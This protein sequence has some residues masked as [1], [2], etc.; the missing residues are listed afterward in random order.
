MRAEYHKLRIGSILIIAFVVLIAAGIFALNQNS[1]H[2]AMK[3]H[4]LEF[5]EIVFTKKVEDKL[6]FIFRK[7]DMLGELTFAKSSMGFRKTS[8]GLEPTDADISYFI[9][10]LDNK[11]ALLIGEVLDEETKDLD[12]L[13]EN[14]MILEPDIFIL[15]EGLFFTCKIENGS[16]GFIRYDIDGNVIE[17]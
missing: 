16:H 15:D 9:I 3:K 13:L 11:Y 6:I 5:N 12:I 17:R 4:D 2:H 1:I 8:Y 14:D 10:M 7:D